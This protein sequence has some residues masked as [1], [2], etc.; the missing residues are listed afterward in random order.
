MIPTSL[1]MAMANTCYYMVTP[2]PVSYTCLILAR[3]DTGEGRWLIYS[4]LIVNDRN[5]NYDY[6][7]IYFVNAIS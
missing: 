6:D 1:L 2:L 7:S 5:S 4:G 3:E